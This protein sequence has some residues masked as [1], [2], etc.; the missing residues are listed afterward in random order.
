MN[1]PIPTSTTPSTAVTDRAPRGLRTFAR[2]TCAG[3]LVAVLLSGT[4]QA[5]DGL[6]RIVADDALPKLSHSDPAV[7]G[8]AALVVAQRPDLAQQTALLA[9]A[10][11]EAPEARQRALVALGLL[12][13]P[14]AVAALG[15]VLADHG[16]RGDDDGIAA[17][18][19]LGLL[20]P[21]HADS[22]V[23]KVL[24][25]FLQGSWK[26]QRE[27]MLALLLAMQLQPARRDLQVLR[28][29]WDDD[30]NRDPEVRGL[31]LQ[32][33]LPTATD[34]DG[35]AVRRLLERGEVPERLAVLHWLATDAP[36][37]EPATVQVVERLGSLADT[38]AVRSQALAVLTR[39]QQPAALDLAVRS[40]R[41]D[42]A[43]ECAQAMRTLAALGGVR[44]VRAFAD[45]IVAET[46]SDRKAAWLA[47]YAAPLTEALATH[48]KKLASDGTQP[49]SLRHAAAVALAHSDPDKAAPLLRDHFRGTSDLA[50][51]PLLARSLRNTH[52]ETVAIDKLVDGIDLFAHRERWGALL[53]IGHA[54]AQREVLATLHDP[55]AQTAKVLSALRAWRHANVLQ[56]P[57]ARREAVPELLRDL[58]ALK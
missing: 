7:R 54:Q 24:S 53:A 6:A 43:E 14:A 15:G 49:W 17:A 13:T 21:G 36:L 23:A 41:S 55:K 32:H 28:R 46:N 58:L 5:Q 25:S 33:L 8:E 48:C 16:T 37:P 1:A 4:A 35:K 3:L 29:L 10:K 34:L 47:N 50:A 26:R 51:L 52:D 40:L 31:L 20:P 12:A 9:L 38:A 42:R 19:G 57:P 45:E 39:W 44:L 2:Q 27:P 56:L 11:D 22:T 18:F 30:S